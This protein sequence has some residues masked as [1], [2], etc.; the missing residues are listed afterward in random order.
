MKILN[1]VTND[2]LS[3]AASAAYR[4]HRNF[5]TLGHDSTMLV[6]NKFSEDQTVIQAEP[7]GAWE[8]RF[9][10][11]RSKI[12][13]FRA[14]FPHV[15][16]FN[17]D[18]VQGI[19]K[20][21][22]FQFGDVDVI[23]LHWVNGLLTSRDIRSLSDFYRCPVVCTIMDQEPL[24][25]GCHYSHG[26]EGYVNRCGQCPQLG[27]TRDDDLSR[28]IW[29]RK[30]QYL[31]PMDM[32]FVAPT[33]WCRTRLQNSGLFRASR[34]S[35]IPLPIN[36]NIFRPFDKIKARQLL[37]IPEDRFVIYF[38]A[39]YLNAPRKGIRYLIDALRMCKEQLDSVAGNK[40]ANVHVVYAGKADSNMEIPFSSQYLGHFRDEV[41]L[42][43][44]YQ[45][46][47]L[48][49]SPS[50]EDAGPMMVSESMM[51]GT[52]V[53]AFDTGIAPDL[54]V[55]GQTGYLARFADVKDMATG[56]VAMLEARNF[57]TM[58]CNA[59][60]IATERHSERCVA[61]AHIKLYEQL[62]SEKRGKS[63]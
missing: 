10:R 14:P 54:I 11:V 25:G 3:G 40:S 49:I 24:T 31:V 20:S 36:E 48:F 46:A 33:S 57:D 17:F 28:K 59:T 37:H 9:Q 42:A 15:S 50:I 44:S 60:Q 29:N 16:D 56:I 58:R 22:Y 18:T 61:S 7:V 53:V 43:L 45:A 63:E 35:E 2:I 4:L 19:D 27:S 5:Q 12:P 39:Q 6:R 32:Q 34:F 38:G 30:F 47:D 23:C 26:C 8:S 62:I 1:F 41:T 55:T 51:C 21:S 52:P 13:F